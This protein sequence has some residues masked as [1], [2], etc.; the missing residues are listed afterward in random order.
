MS[1]G[2]AIILAFGTLA[3][4]SKYGGTA[5]ITKFEY[6]NII[7]SLVVGSVFCIWIGDQITVKGFG[8][9]TS[10]L[11]FVNIISRIP[12]SLYSLYQSEKAGSI[13]VVELTLFLVGAAILLAASIYM[14]LAERKIPVQYAGKAVGSRV[15]KGQSTHI[16]LSLISA[17]VIAII[18]AMSVMGFTQALGQFFPNNGVLNWL[19]TSKYSVFNDQTWMYPVCYAVLTVFFTWFYKEITLKPDEMAENLNKS[20]GFVTG[21]RPGVETEKY[22]SKVIAK[23]SLIGG[24]FAAILAVIPVIVQNHSKFGQTSFGATAF[25]IVIG[26]ALDFSRRLESQMVMRHYEGFL[27]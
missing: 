25:L 5:D 6:A 17:A 12:K 3:T 8:N 1:I 26:V 16:P 10:I 19:N 24:I 15:M 21:V 7:V 27:K 22:F 14:S 4:I 13:N 2:I 11:I 9:G 18:F 23:I 20:A